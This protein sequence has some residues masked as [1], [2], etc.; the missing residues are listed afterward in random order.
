MKMKMKPPVRTLFAASVACNV[1]LWFQLDQAYEETKQL[2]A[3]FENWVDNGY[4]LYPRPDEE[5]EVILRE[6]PG[7]MNQD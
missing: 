4:V 7:H 6:V 1:Y 2:L 3:R 5:E